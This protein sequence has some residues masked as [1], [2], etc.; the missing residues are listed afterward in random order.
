MRYVTRE[1]KLISFVLQG[2]PR[3]NRSQKSSVQITQ[4]GNS[5]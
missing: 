3:A 1:K 5:R 4:K 2:V